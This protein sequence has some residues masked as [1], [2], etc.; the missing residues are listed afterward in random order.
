MSK[1]PNLPGH[2]HIAC[3]HCGKVLV[4]CKCP[5]SKSCKGHGICDDC[6]RMGRPF[7]TEEEI[8]AEKRKIDAMTQE[9][10]ARLH[11]FAPSGH[12]YF[13][14]RLPLYGHFKKRFKGMTPEISKH[15]GWEA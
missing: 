6:E 9:E 13:D 12:P 7:L 15:I 11:R 4:S 10:L 14:K 5:D 8:E 2:G 3:L 1:I